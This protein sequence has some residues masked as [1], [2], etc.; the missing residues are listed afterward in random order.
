L[1]TW[2]R[3][4]LAQRHVDYLREARRAEALAN[5]ADQP[6]PVAIESTD[7]ESARYLRVIGVAIENALSALAARDRTRLAYYY[8]Q[9]LK[10]REMRA[11]WVRA[12]PACRGTWH[13]PAARC[14]VRSSVHSLRNIN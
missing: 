5:R 13:A 8:R 14:A 12:N 6:D 9:G 1:T 11:S 3:A 10:L 4:V 2:L 7:G